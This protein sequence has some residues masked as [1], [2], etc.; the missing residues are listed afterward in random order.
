MKILGSKKRVAV[1]TLA[2][3]AT[4]AATAVQAG[5]VKAE[6]PLQGSGTVCL[7]Q[8]AARAL[9]AQHVTISATGAATG[10]GNCV[11]FPGSGTLS[12][13]LTGGELPLQG[14]MRF[15]RGGS[16]LDMTHLVIH[17]RLGKGHTSADIAQNGAPGKNTT[18]FRFPVSLSKVSFTP[19]TV[20]TKDIP[21]TLTSEGA[22]AFADTFGVAPL[23]AD[24]PLLAFD[25]QARITSPFGGLPKP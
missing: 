25:G 1:L 11:T 17:I 18:V 20:D 24:A 22:T 13:D 10:S 6:L 23:P 21:L 7:T 16:H 9:D 5:A 14:G 19:A 2:V 15:A 3:G 12:P 4:L 8:E